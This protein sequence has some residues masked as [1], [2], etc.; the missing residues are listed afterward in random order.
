[1]IL[2]KAEP[3]QMHG[4]QRWRKGDEMKKRFVIAALV[5][6]SV[7]SSSCFFATSSTTVKGYVHYDDKPV[8]GAEITFG[9]KFGEA[10][11]TTSPDGKFTITVKH[12]PTAMLEVKVKKAGYGQREEIKFPGFAAPSEQIDIELMTI[13]TPTK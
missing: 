10:K 1:M 13:F 6:T 8:S 11:T 7:F 5:I 9:P 2:K 12:R 4:K 3:F